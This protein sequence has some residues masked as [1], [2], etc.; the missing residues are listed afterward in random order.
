MRI[1]SPP[2]YINNH[3]LYPIF[4]IP[5]IYSNLIHGIYYYCEDSNV[6]ILD[7]TGFLY[8]M[9]GVD[10]TNMHI[11]H[12]RYETFEYN[13]ISSNYKIFDGSTYDELRALI[14]SET[15]R[16]VMDKLV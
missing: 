7:C 12:E 13:D 9:K 8:A 16:I 15:F 14:E 2:E 10:C 5:N 4:I 11:R 3:K 1:S 6:Y